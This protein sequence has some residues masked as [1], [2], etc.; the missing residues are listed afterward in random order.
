MLGRRTAN[1]VQ[2]IGDTITAKAEAAEQ[3]ADAPPPR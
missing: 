1:V 3:A 2:L